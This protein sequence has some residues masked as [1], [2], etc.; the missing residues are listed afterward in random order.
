MM[1]ALYASVSGLKTHQ[2]KMDVI[3]NNIAN[4]NTVG[5]KS[6]RTT[7]S[8]M[9]Y[10]NLSFA[11]GAN[12]QTGKGGVNAKQIGLGT[13]FAS[14][15]IDI[16]TGGAPESTGKAFDLKL[17]DKNST[18]FYIVNTGTENVFTRAGAFYVDGAGNLC[19]ESTGY[20]VMGWQVDANGN[21][22][23]DTVS[24]LRIMSADNQTSNPEYTTKAVCSGIL[25]DNTSN[26]NSDQGYKMNLNFYD[27]LGYSYTAQFAAQKTGEPKDGEYTINLTDIVDS[28]GKS[29][30]TKDTVG[31]GALFGGGQGS[32]VDITDRYKVADGMGNALG[33]LANATAD[34]TTGALQY[35]FTSDYVNEMLGPS[36]KAQRLPSGLTVQITCNPTITPPATVPTIQSFKIIDSSGAPFDYSSYKWI[37]QTQSN[38]N[39]PVAVT[40]TNNAF[41]VTRAQDDLQEMIESGQVSANKDGKYLLSSG[42]VNS[43]VTKYKDILGTDTGT[44]AGADLEII[45]DANKKVTGLQWTPAQANP[46]AIGGGIIVPATLLGASDVDYLTDYLS[47]GYIT[48]QASAV[49][50]RGIF[51]TDVPSDAEIR[52][53]PGEK[54]AWSYTVVTPGTDGY[55]AQFSTADGSLTYIGSEGNKTQTLRL[56]NYRTQDNQ[57]SDIEIDFSTLKNL[58]NGASST[59]AMSAGNAGEGEGKRVGAL[60]GLS[61]DQSGM[62]YGSYSNGNTTLLGQIAVARF[63]NASGLESIGENCYRTTMN[64]GQF[65]GIGVEMDSD[66]S[67]IDSGTLEMSN[68]DLA[69]EFTMMITTQRGY[70]ANSRVIST[71]DSILEE[72]VNLKR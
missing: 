51:T 25:D 56:S 47:Q 29:I 53:V 22:R 63:G 17:S 9:M 45:L 70:Q 10:Q 4:V 14:T 16:D 50:N 33:T 3:G 35:N 1:R 46:P 54:G 72:L 28:N 49:N 30:L 67:T 7:F 38:H 13:T 61:V 60:I 69:T 18:S 24:P 6:S 42:Q 23:K 8:T 19:M 58:S 65:D 66:G 68:V 21:I 55:K 26:V 15:A 37:N 57:F 20:Q 62:I 44:I 27:N 43:L 12:V 2:T 40:G 31:L 48:V 34:A 59:A 39:P 11:S 36:D 5:F 71:S 64:S 41:K 32:C 52:Y